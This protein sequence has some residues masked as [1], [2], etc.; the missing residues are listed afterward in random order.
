MV[1]SFTHLADLDRAVQGSH[2]V[3]PALTGGGD[4][5]A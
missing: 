3:D 2:V 1:K 5:T 4:S